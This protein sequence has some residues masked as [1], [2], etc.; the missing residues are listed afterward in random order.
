MPDELDD[1][2]AAIES[3]ADFY[4]RIVRRLTT[5]LIVT[6][7]VLIGTAAYLVVRANANATALCDSNRTTTV[8]AKDIHRLT[9][10]DRNPAHYPVPRPC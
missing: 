5:Y 4:N 2:K 6:F 7:L 1:V 9:T 10:G 3:R 8:I